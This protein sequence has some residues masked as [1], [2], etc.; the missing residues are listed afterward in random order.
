MCSKGG[1]DAA[2]PVVDAGDASAGDAGQD[3]TVPDASDA[4]QDVV[5]VVDATADAKDS[6]VVMSDASDASTSD[7]PVTSAKVIVTPASGSTSESGT[8]FAVTVELSAA[9][10]APVTIGVTSSNTAEGTVS[11]ASLTFTTA[12]W[13]VKQTVTV[14]G[15]AD[16]TWDYDKSYTVVFAASTSADPAWS[17]VVGTPVAM[18]NVDVDAPVIKI[19]SATAS[20][21]QGNGQS[22]GIS[23]TTSAVLGT[24][25][26]TT[27]GQHVF[28]ASEATNFNG[29]DPDTNGV[30]DVYENDRSS[31][32]QFAI[33][34]FDGQGSYNAASNLPV[35][36][37][38]GKYVAFRTLAT[39]AEP[40]INPGCVLRNTFANS[41]SQL[42]TSTDC[43]P[44]DVSADG[45]YALFTELVSGATTLK[46][47]DRTSTS[48][49][50]ITALGTPTSASMS[51]NGQYVAFLS[52]WAFAADD[53]NS[54]TDLYVY[55]MQTSAIPFRVSKKSDGSQLAN[56]ATAGGISGDGNYV[57]FVT[58]DAAVSTDTDTDADLYH[59]HRTGLTPMDL[60]SRMSASGA[61]GLGDVSDDGR[62]YAFEFTPSGAATYKEVW[63]YDRV[64]QTNKSAHKTYNGGVPNGI[65][66]R[67]AIS[68]DGVWL[69]FVGYASNLVA[70]DTNGKADVFMVPRP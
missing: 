20:A 41:Y 1:V 18:T 49:T 62:Y 5:P 3:A 57:W 68:G 43:V 54:T 28:Y 52:T 19:A 22:G 50:T 26:L 4:A 47:F 9:P 65:T 69:A 15:V 17:G 40:V 31:L 27:S 51:T 10:S 34:G 59:A 61:V 60:A 48:S 42:S 21:V 56:G 67:P 14:T 24:P 37:G 35:V 25:S 36:S 44:Y 8:T 58:R 16:S 30:S 63:V 7:V 32:F 66:E 53:T 55:D 12:T 6:G 45:R 23:A 11:P 46:R 64:N 2:Q 39:Y 70:T 13:S 29:N 33:S 38:D